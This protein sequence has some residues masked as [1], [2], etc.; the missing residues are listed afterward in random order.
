M[1][2]QVM[3][4]SIIASIMATQTRQ[5]EDLKD[6]VRSEINTTNKRID[7]IVSDLIPIEEEQPASKKQKNNGAG[8]GG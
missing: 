1:D 3:Q 7:G 6:L 2:M 8:K 4:D 5:F